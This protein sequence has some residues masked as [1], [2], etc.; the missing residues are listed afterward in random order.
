VNVATAASDT[1]VLPLN[2]TNAK[3]VSLD[4]PAAGSARVI[5]AG[6]VDLLQVKLA[7]S[8]AAAAKLKIALTAE[9]FFDWTKAKTR[10]GTYA[11]SYTFSNTSNTSIGNYA[12]RVLLPT[13]FSMT[14]VTSSTPRATGEEVEP[15]YD[16]ASEDGRLS[17]N[18]R[19][20]TVPPGRTAAI[21]F[22]FQPSGRNPLPPIVIG[23]IIIG[24]ALYL[25]RDVLTR[26]DYSRAAPV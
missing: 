26:T 9:R 3:D 5:K 4:P 24:L 2:F 23:A 10:R 19:A 13:G 18:L 14:G 12:L 25:K 17:V 22:A 21:A 16:F 8:P 6:D 11:F 20:K 1:L 15:P 7:Q